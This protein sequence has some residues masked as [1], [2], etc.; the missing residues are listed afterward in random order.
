MSSGC[1]RRYIHWPWPCVGVGVLLLRNWIPGISWPYSQCH[2]CVILIS[3]F[4]TQLAIFYWPYRK[5]GTP[6]RPLS[7]Y[8]SIISH[9]FSYSGWF[10]PPCR[11]R[12][13]NHRS[14]HLHRST[15]C[16]PVPPS[17]C[18]VCCGCGQTL[19]GAVPKVVGDWQ[20]QWETNQKMKN[21]RP[22]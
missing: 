20:R 10:H 4:P 6:K 8:I 15:L 14:D 21:H 22:W 17:A 9:F 19:P 2:S 3:L 16:G 12:I 5:S 18:G 1:G 11:L 7:Q 13:L